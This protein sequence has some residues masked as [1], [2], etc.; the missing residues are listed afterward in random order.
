MWEAGRTLEMD[1]QGA[2]R[3]F[4]HG[5]RRASRRACQRPGFVE[6]MQIEFDRGGEIQAEGVACDEEVRHNVSAL[7]QQMTQME[8]GNAQSCSAMHRITFWPELFGEFLAQMDAAFHRQI[9]E[10]REFL[11]CGELQHLIGMAHFRWTQ[12]SEA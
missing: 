12:Q 10:K 5:E 7:T 1:K 8:Q 6:G 2:V 9:E 4:R 11:A 3:I